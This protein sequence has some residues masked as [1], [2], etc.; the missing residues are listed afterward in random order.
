MAKKNT[1]TFFEDIE[2]DEELSNILD[3]QEED[4]EE[5]PEDEYVPIVPPPPQP[6]RTGRPMIVRE[7]RPDNLTTVRRRVPLTKSMCR[8]PRCTYDAAV[9]LGYPA[10]KNVPMNRREECKLMLEQHIAQAH[11]FNDSHIMFEDDIQRQFFGVDER[12]NPRYK[13]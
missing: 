7:K 4:L 5:I 10:Y 9:H 2:M 3:E 13:V 1:A 8:K 11:S 6:K 12:G